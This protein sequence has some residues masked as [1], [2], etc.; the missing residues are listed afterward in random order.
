MS[1]SSKVKYLP[2]TVSI[3]GNNLGGRVSKH[4]TAS[5]TRKRARSTRFSKV[6]DERSGGINLFTGSTTCS[7]YELCFEGFGVILQGFHENLSLW[8]LNNSKICGICL[9][10]LSRSKAETASTIPKPI[11]T[12][13]G[14]NSGPHSRN[15]YGNS[16]NDRCIG[17]VSLTRLTP[18]DE[19]E[20]VTAQ[21]SPGK[22]MLYG[23]VP[24][25]ILLCY[26]TMLVTFADSGS[27]IAR[28][29]PDNRICEVDS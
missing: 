29:P 28:L 4:K 10:G 17:H 5:N 1:Q 23:T 25:R 9:R 3:V 12:I 18:G 13:E 19:A 20:F 8:Q 6:G 24:R 22:G 7:V 14:R 2:K 26:S 16:P 27:R 11:T 21:P 15:R